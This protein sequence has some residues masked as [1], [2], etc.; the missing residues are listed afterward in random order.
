MDGEW[1]GGLTTYVYDAHGRLCGIQE[2]RETFVYDGTGQVQAN[3]PVPGK[4]GPVA[5][6]QPVIQRG[7]EFRLCGSEVQEQVV[8]L[9]GA[10]G[11]LAVAFNNVRAY[12][13]R[14]GESTTSSAIGG[15]EVQVALRG[16][17]AVCTARITDFAAEDLV[18]VQVDVVV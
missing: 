15:V 1:I 13:T 18:V 11:A 14:C 2:P 6:G 10:S 8:A 16:N 3:A 7:V 5:A 12:L 4:A 9:D 17:Q